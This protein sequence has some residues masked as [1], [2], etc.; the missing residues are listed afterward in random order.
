MRDLN[1]PAG[2][3][4]YFTTGECSDYQ[5]EGFFVSLDVISREKLLEVSDGIKKGILSKELPVDSWLDVEDEDD[6]DRAVKDH[7]L[8]GCI[9]AG[10][11]LE[12]DP[13][14]Y[15]LGGYGRLELFK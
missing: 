5:I 9:R 6:V 7:F 3:L 4:L 1:L 8:A 15:H 12:I 14:E 2:R 11:L 13:K 10:L